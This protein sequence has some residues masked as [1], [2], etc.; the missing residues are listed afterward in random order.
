MKR[1]RRKLLFSGAK[2]GGWRQKPR[3]CGFRRL[4]TLIPAD[5][6]WRKFGEADV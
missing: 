5:R 2:R 4:W 1:R 3:F 6:L